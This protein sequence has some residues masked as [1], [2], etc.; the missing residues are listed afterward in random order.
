M[1]KQYEMQNT[2]EEQNRLQT[3]TVI[4]MMLEK[5]LLSDVQID[6]T[7][8]RAARQKRMRTAYHNTLMLLKNYR[9]IV[10]LMKCFP[11][12]IAA[13]LDQPFQNLDKLIDGVDIE[14][15]IGNKKLENRVEGIKKS[16]LL[17]DRVNEALTVL[18]KKPENGELLYELLYLTYINPNKTDFKTILVKLNISSSQYY[19]LRDVAINIVSIRLWASPSSEIDYWL[20]ILTILE[21]MNCSK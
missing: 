15:A 10:W 13:E 2:N 11:G 16:R 6:S 12:A 3:D 17:I 18:K 19:R 20:D 4:K 9:N 8:I 1:K 5:G 7:H 21:D 14:M